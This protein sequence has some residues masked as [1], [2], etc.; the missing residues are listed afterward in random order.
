VRGQ[1]GIVTIN[2]RCAFLADI[3]GRLYIVVISVHYILL[4]VR[5]RHVENIHA[6]V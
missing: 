6:H 2:V 4:D 3:E 5:S 1:S